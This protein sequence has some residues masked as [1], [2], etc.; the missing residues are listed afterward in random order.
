MNK[1]IVKVS[2]GILLFSVIFMNVSNKIID[3]NSYFLEK[4]KDSLTDVKHGV[5]DNK[6]L[7]NVIDNVNAENGKKNIDIDKNKDKDKNDPASVVFTVEEFEDYVLS[8]NDFTNSLNYYYLYFWYKMKYLTA[9]IGPYATSKRLFAF[10]G[11]VATVLF[12]FYAILKLNYESTRGFCVWLFGEE[13]A[14]YL[15]NP[16]LYFSARRTLRNFDMELA[17]DEEEEELLPRRRH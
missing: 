6:N 10:I 5:F 9:D 12:F 1:K 15:F 13:L 16:Q 17:L 2:L 11:I 7:N 8:Q 14:D 3:S 4:E